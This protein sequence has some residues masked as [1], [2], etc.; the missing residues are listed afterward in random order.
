MLDVKYYIL[1]MQNIIDIIL[2]EQNSYSI[3]RN[4]MKELND[5]INNK[6]EF[7]NNFSVH[8]LNFIEVFNPF[9]DMLIT[10]L[11]EYEKELIDN[12]VLSGEYNFV[13]NFNEFYEKNILL[14]FKDMINSLMC[15]YEDDNKLQGIVFY[16]HLN[17]LLKRYKFNNNKIKI[18]NNIPV[19][20]IDYGARISYYKEEYITRFRHELESGKRVGVFIDDNELL[21]YIINSLK[22]L[23]D[24]Y[25][26]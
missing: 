15:L 10:K 18:I 11:E 4:I 7:D 25:D 13:F 3:D 20:E 26:Y 6:K 17:T 12:K 22:D 14:P 1:C 8:Y 24:K 19:I 9:F 5:Y 23:K 2:K 16:L 21:N